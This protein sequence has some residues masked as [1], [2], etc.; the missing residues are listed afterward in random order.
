M[1]NWLIM[2]LKLI[3]NIFLLNNVECSYT[4]F[5]IRVE[6]PRDSLRQFAHKLT[7]F[8]K[9]FLTASSLNYAAAI[10]PG[11]YVFLCELFVRILYQVYFRNPS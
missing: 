2:D 10:F 3:V 6:Y 4:L 9:L 7:H 8:I 1:K 11:F 5:K